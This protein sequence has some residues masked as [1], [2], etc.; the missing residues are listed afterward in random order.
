MPGNRTACGSAH[1]ADPLAV[2]IQQ[3]TREL[4][5][6]AAPLCATHRATLPDPVIRLDLR[7][8]A[9]G[10]AQWRPDGTPVL[11]F[12]RHFAQRHPADFLA[13]TVAHEVAHLITVAC[14]GR[15]PPHGHEWRRVMAYLGIDDAERCHNYPLDPAEGRRQRRWTYRCD[16]SDHQ[17]STTRHN[18][19]QNGARYHCRRCDA[20][21]RRSD[22]A[23]D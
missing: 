17:L 22:A 16:C 19:I 12:N 8:R 14:F 11:R 13:R 7:G 6:L 18:R 3:R 10:Q 9:A 20:P 5:E 2:Q 21:L 23:G 15:T 4:L 1:T